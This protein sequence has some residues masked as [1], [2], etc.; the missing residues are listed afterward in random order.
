MVKAAKERMTRTTRMLRT[1]KNGL[2]LWDQANDLAALEMNGLNGEMPT[3]HCAVKLDDGNYALGTLGSGLLIM[4]R[5]GRIVDVINST[6]GLQDDLILG[7]YQDYQRG[8]W[9]GLFNG[10]SNAFSV[11]INILLTSN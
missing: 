2:Y 6:V 9:L 5:S 11:S 8:L 1:K 7:I 10:I 4:E 3:L